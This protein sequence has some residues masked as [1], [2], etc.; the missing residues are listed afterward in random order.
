M[1]IP[2]PS[3]YPVHFRSQDLSLTIT[4][5]LNHTFLIYLSSNLLSTEVIFLKYT[6]KDVTSLNQ[7]FMNKS[8]TRQIL[9]GHFSWASCCAGL[10][11]FPGGQSVTTLLVL[12]VRGGRNTNWGNKLNYKLCWVLNQNRNKWRVLLKKKNKGQ[13]FFSLG[14]RSLSE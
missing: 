14:Q 13:T 11:R 9:S 6:S 1:L 4:C 3:D 2:L 7:A 12:T 10:C 5:F 8:F